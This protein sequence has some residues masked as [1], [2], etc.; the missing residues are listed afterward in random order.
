VSQRR[1]NGRCIAVRRIRRSNLSFLDKRQPF[2]AAFLFARIL[3]LSRE[4]FLERRGASA[5]R[6]T[7]PPI[8]EFA[9]INLEFADRAAQCVAMHAK[10]TSGAA[11][12]AL[13]LFED[14]SDETLLEF[15]D[16]LRIENIAPVHLLYE[17]FQLVFHMN[18]AFRLSRSQSAKS[19]LLLATRM[20]RSLSAP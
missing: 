14:R 4:F 15:P 12:I 17:R 13:V 19:K 9:D 1:P 18:L 3:G 8:A 16:R 10:L 5:S 2:A 20:R 6:R 11:L 7:L